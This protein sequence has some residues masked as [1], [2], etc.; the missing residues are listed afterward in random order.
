[1]SKNKLFWVI[2]IMLVLLIIFIFVEI[3]PEKCVLDSDCVVFGESGDCNCGC[4]LKGNL[5]MTTGGKCFCA[6]PSSCK[7][8]E[9]KCEGVFSN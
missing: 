7:C 8:V 2:L 3:E 9:G 5:P 4:Y 1:M 6:A